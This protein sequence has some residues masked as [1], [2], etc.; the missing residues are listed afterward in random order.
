MAFDYEG[1]TPFVTK[2]QLEKIIIEGD[3]ITIGFKE[4]YEDAEGNFIPFGSDHVTFT[5]EGFLDAYNSAEDKEE[6]IKEIIGRHIHTGVAYL[7]A[8]RIS[9]ASGR[10][11]GCGFLADGI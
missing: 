3:S 5:D 10:G 11:Q 6:F 4:G 1:S 8:G 7:L 9:V 2:A